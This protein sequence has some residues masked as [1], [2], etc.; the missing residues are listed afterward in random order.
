MID[1]NMDVEF[2]E[3]LATQIQK[4]IFARSRPQNKVTNTIS[5]YPLSHYCP[6]SIPEIHD[7]IINAKLTSQ[8][9]SQSDVEALVNRLVY[10]GLVYK[11]DGEEY[12][13][14]SKPSLS[15]Y[16]QYG[17]GLIEKS[18]AYSDSP[19]GIRIH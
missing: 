9:L 19:C 17:S 14:S 6:T 1:N 12:Y 5:L 4:Y 13:V 7:W 16:N 11:F 10:D 18:R 2:I 15:G 8:P 3:Q